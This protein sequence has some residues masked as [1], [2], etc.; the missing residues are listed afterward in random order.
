MCQHVSGKRQIEEN[1]MEQFEMCL[2]NM[3]DEPN[4]VAWR[5]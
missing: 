3:I 4:L 5:I 2:S 1:D